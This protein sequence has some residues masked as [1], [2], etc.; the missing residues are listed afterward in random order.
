MWIGRLRPVG[1]A[2]VV[3]NMALE[4]GGDAVS[5]KVG[6]AVLTG[7]RQDD[8]VRQHELVLVDAA[9]EVAE[10]IVAARNVVAEVWPVSC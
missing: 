7:L 10:D 2:K 8:W 3:A 9:L 5:P 4:K 1:A 6:D